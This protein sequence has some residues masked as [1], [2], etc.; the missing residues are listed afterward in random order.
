MAELNKKLS[1]IEVRVNEVTIALEA[2]STPKE[3][4][5]EQPTQP[6][7]EQTTEETTQVVNEQ[8]SA[9]VTT[10]EQ[11]P[12]V[13]SD[14]D[15]EAEKQE[16]LDQW[17]GKLIAAS[18]Q[19]KA[20]K[21]EIRALEKKVSK[22]DVNVQALKEKSKGVRRKTYNKIKRSCLNCYKSACW[23]SFF[24]YFRVKHK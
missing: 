13:Q 10:T 7:S 21:N 5:T 17:F 15:D 2:F 16:E 20:V 9:T 19:L 8:D 3:Q 23:R 6:Q 4:P 18:N 1:K 12:V 22:N 14:E 24:A 11:S